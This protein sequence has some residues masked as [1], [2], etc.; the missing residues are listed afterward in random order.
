MRSFPPEQVASHV[1]MGI[2]H[3]A[4]FSPLFPLGEACSRMDLTAIHE[5]LESVGFKDDEGMT[6]EVR[7]H[8]SG[9]FA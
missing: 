7:I 8:Q 4:S 3:S 6:N 9:K 5:I 1:L 2:P